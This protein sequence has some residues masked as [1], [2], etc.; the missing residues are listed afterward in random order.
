MS[1]LSDY[2][3]AEYGRFKE[4][5]GGLG[6]GFIPFISSSD[7]DNGVVGYFSIDFDFRNIIT[8]ARTGSVGSS[9][10]HPYKCVANS[11]C[12]VLA[13]KKSFS[14]KE[15]LIFTFLLNKNRFKYSYARKVTPERVLKTNIP[16]DIL[17]LFKDTKIPTISEMSKP[18]SNKEIKLSDRD[19]KWFAYSDI[20]DITKGK[21]LTTEE[22]VSGSIPYISSSS[23]NNGVDDY[24]SN[25]FTDEN[26]IT[27]ACYGSIGEVF[28]QPQKCWVSDNCNVFYVKNQI[29]N[30]YIALFLCRLFRKEQFRFSYGMTGKM[31]RLKTFK[32][33]LPT[34]SNGQPDWQF[35]EDY[36]KSLPYSG[37]I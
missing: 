16:E 12:I 9:F 25:G 30:Q 37:A 23:I 36:I 28:Y 31:E 35:M 29:L 34:N 6:N 15:M 26:C 14:Q 33:K 3:T 4:P 13:P 21:R 8:V 27:F 24:I 19:W 7:T 10:Y 32:L 11:D 2:F 17:R 20:F 18:I 1:I 22:R 5:F